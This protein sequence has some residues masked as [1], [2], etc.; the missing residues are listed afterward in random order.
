MDN[1]VKNRV[2]LEANNFLDNKSTVRAVSKEIGTSK[3]T[4]HKDF[5]EKLKC[6][7]E[8]LYIKVINQL[9]YNKDIRH[10][11]GGQA[12]KEYYKNKKDSF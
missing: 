10:I 9:Q 6:I 11:R 3:S 7:D 5:T 1:K 8:G 4:V 12:T 2:L